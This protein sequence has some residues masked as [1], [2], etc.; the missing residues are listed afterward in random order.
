L[1]FHWFTRMLSMVEGSRLIDLGAGH[2]KFSLIAAD[3][4]WQ[5]TALDARGDRYPGDARIEWRVGD[6]RDVDLTAFDVVACLGL[7]YH[8]TVEDQLALLDRC[9]GRPI[10]LDTHVANGKP[11]P[12]PLSEPVKLLG[13]QG[14][15]YKEP[16]QA[17][18]STASW[19]N[20]DSFWPR[21]GALFRMLNERGYDV[22]EANPWYVPTRTFFLCL[23][24]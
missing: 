10:I 1:R 22:L 21:P 8:L 15:L 4:G 9:R 20:D 24:S 19:G 3:K 18:H 13:Y 16:D 14:Q 5:V 6:V 2:G 11:S 17:L 12:Y 7:F 23:P